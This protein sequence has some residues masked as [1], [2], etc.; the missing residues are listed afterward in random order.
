MPK[1]AGVNAVHALLY[2]KDPAKARA[3]LREVLGWR[4]VD[5]G[6][7]WLIFAMPP[8]E[9]GVH[10]VMPGEAAAG[11]VEIYL[12]CDD[13]RKTA[14]ELRRRGAKVAAKIS[15]RGWGLVTSVQVPGAG[16][17]GLYQPRHPVAWRSPRATRRPKSKRRR[18]G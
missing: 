3:F 7:G 16:R 8:A 13:V 2:A 18:G 10:P 12:M 4:S 5:A 15:D 1:S 14:A 11:H 6:E 9:V 17:I